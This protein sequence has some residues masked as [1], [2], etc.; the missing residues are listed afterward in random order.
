M[1]S[2]ALCD[3]AG[4]GSVAVS[5]IMSR[6]Q[7]SSANLSLIGEAVPLSAL[8]RFED[9][10]LA[11]RVLD[12]AGGAGL[13]AVPVSGRNFLSSAGVASLI[14]GRR[15]L[16][17]SFRGTSRSR[18]C[19]GDCRL[20]RGALPSPTLRPVW[21]VDWRVRAHGRPVQD[22]PGCFLRGSLP[23]PTLCPGGVVDWRVWAHGRPV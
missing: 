1:S 10:A 4:R 22:F 16:P 23:P 14:L 20:F 5:R 19:L 15:L 21:V 3:L 8:R 2:P 9:L 6:V 7:T 11:E 12:A 18:G 17:F 13:R